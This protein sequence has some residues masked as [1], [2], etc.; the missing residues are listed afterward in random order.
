MPEGEDKELYR[1]ARVAGQAMFIP[2]FLV[3]F[4]LAFYWVGTQL[5][6]WWGTEPW[7]ARIFLLLGLVSAFRQVTK[8]IRRIMSDTS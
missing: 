1:L 8:V 4:P 2:I 5:D 7:L 6:S 3:L